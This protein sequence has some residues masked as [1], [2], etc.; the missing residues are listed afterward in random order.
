MG[1]KMQN[2]L[3]DTIKN[4][5]ESKPIRFHMPAHNGEDIDITT[6]MDVTELSFSDNLIESDGV[7]ALCEKNIATAYGTNYALM[8]TTG[9]TTGVAIALSTARNIGKKLL[10]VGDLHKSVYN[11]A[12][13]FGFETTHTDSLSCINSNNNKDRSV[14]DINN[15]VRN[16]NSNATNSKNS[17]NINAVN[18]TNG[19][20]SNKINADDFDA[21]I[22]TSPD[23][24]G[25]TYDITCL[26]DTKALV[27]VDA[28]HGAH[29]AF[30]D[31]LPNLDTDTADITILS[32][33]KTLPVLTGGAG[34]LCNDRNIYDMLC[35]SRSVL[36]SSSPNY[37]TMASIDKSISNFFSNG[38]RL[39]DN[40]LQEIEIFKSS[41]CNRYKVLETNDKTRLCISANKISGKEILSQLERQNIYL[42]MAYNDI[43]VAIVTPYNCKHLSVLARALNDINCT[44]QTEQINIKK[45]SKIGTIC[46][47]VK[48]LPIKECLNKVSAGNIGI[49]PP[50]TPII[51]VGDLIDSQIIDF[52]Q[53]T[54]CEIFGLING[55][56][57]IFDE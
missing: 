35:Y 43:L 45:P 19:D 17:D 13:I 1:A 20:N 30:S 53:S 16:D 6:A 34:L 32:F 48:F 52:L 49:Y 27:I 33:H 40:C 36:H 23:Y 44:T 57:P 47:K 50:G 31:K 28:S 21:V 56:L 24:F 2:K 9:A 42:E 5:A 51:T 18:G 3:F 7:I 37:L 10:M 38:Q 11:Y 25:K 4:Y 46:K 8:L 15:G 22:L 14:S 26:K 29:F 41:L 12:N 55:K 39:Y 54:D